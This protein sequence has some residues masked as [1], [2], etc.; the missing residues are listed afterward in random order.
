[1]KNLYALFLLVFSLITSC[2]I[3][4]K[5]NDE[6]PEAALDWQ[7]G[8]QAYTF[9]R[10][11]FFEAIDKIKTC[12]LNYVEAYPGQIIGGGIEGK[13]DYKMPAEKRDKISQMLKEKGVQPVSFGVV[14]ADNEADWRQIFE[15]VK[16]MGMENITSEPKEKDIP[17]LSELCDEYKINLAIH[18]HPQPSHYWHPEVVLKAIEG[19]SKRIGACAD[20]GHWV[21][22]GLNPVE[23]L[24]KLE[25]KIIQLHMKDLN[26]K[27][28]KEAH[29]VH[30][31]KG[32]SNVDGVLKELKRQDFKGLFSVEYEHNWKNN[33]PDVIE[34]VN[35]FRKRVRELK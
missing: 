32:V 23:C 16:A 35:Y 28:V 9:N 26:K 22:S 29:D 12:D 20:I 4:H 25:G 19:Q 21:R 31:G 1:M 14:R 8:A 3:T 2:S 10:F 34:S 27:G 24:K 11:T 17:L 15:F 7:L 6:I 33:V 5:V 13:M 30:W 18:N